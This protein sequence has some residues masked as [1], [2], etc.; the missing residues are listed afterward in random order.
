MGSNLSLKQDSKTSFSSY[1]FLFQA[2]FSQLPETWVSSSFALEQ[3]RY[4]LPQYY[5]SCSEIWSSAY[6]WWCVSTWWCLCLPVNSR[7]LFLF[8]LFLWSTI[9]YYV[10]LFDK[11]SHSKFHI[12]IYIHTYIY[13]YIYWLHTWLSNHYKVWN[14]K[15][16][17]TK[18][19]MHT[20]NLFRKE[21][22]SK[23]AYWF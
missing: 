23:P 17:N 2:H 15:K 1:F 18:R 14:Y 3:P 12:Y 7:D 6:R 20:E 5:F 11:F 21:L 16:R 13:I 4:N 19:L 9:P 8:H 22:Q 10:N